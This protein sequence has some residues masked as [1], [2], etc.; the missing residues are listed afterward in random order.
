MTKSSVLRTACIILLLCATTAIA[1]HAQ[2]FTLLAPFDGTNGTS[3]GGVIQGP[4]G[5]FYGITGE[6]GLFNAGTVFRAT[7][8]GAITSLYS[9][10]SQNCTTGYS[11]DY[12]YSPFANLVLGPD[13]D[14]YGTTAWGGTGSNAA[15]SGSGAVGCGTVFKITAS[16]TLTTLHSFSG[17]EGAVPSGMVLGTDGNLYGAATQG[18]ANSNN[19]TIFKIT[20]PSG[21]LT[22]LY[23]FCSQ[24]N[25]TDGGTPDANGPLIQGTDGN[26]YG[27][28]WYSGNP[29]NCDGCS[30]VFKITPGG[31]FTTLGVPGGYSSGGVVQATDGNF[32]G[33]GALAG[34]LFEVTRSGVA[35]TLASVC[36][37]PY[38]PLIQ[39][40][41]GNLYG[42]TFT[43]GN[44]QECNGYGCGTIFEATLPPPPTLLTLYPFCSQTDCT[45]GGGPMS[46]LLQATNGNFYGTTNA[47]YG[48][49][50]AGT[51]FELSTGLG[52]F[53]KTIPTS[54]KVGAK[55]LILGNK[56]K[57]ASSVSFNGTDATFK[58][59]ESA[60]TTTVPAGATTGSIIVTA[61]PERALQSNL[62][63]RVMPQLTSFTPSSG[64]VGT[65]VQ[66]TGV[67][68][69]QTTRVAFDGV[70]ASFTVDSDT[71]VTVTVPTGATTGKIGVTTKG[72]TATSTTSFTVTIPP[73]PQLAVSV[74]SA[75]PTF[76]PGGT[77]SYTITVSNTGNEAT[78]GTITMV[79]TLASAE[80]PGSIGGGSEWVCDLSTVTCTTTI[81]L[82]PGQTFNN[83]TLDVVI[84]SD[85]SGSITAAFTA[86]GDGSIATTIVTNPT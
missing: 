82:A 29:G 2:T 13:G 67:S 46:A 57:N 28:T 59:S 27:V 45:D 78:S 12:G 14:F 20:L 10:C 43:G 9:F 21:T 11:P 63:F 5:N 50:D 17:T 47:D 40:T 68:L 73:A 58:A 66:I 16:G 1:A 15:C 44:T 79:A 61:S 3:P 70:S 86:S 76:A 33:T 60:I 52:P 72:G 62:T 37:Y 25:C 85:A 51:I 35:T 34:T 69:T 4:D 24:A 42:T 36:C 23:D 83:I 8:E 55:V 39:A 81:S 64:P 31:T 18:G 49:Y 32:Y 19:G 22:K 38:G 53:V 26:F 56:L 75:P 48:Q 6:G 74:T 80:T 77:G 65:Q 84:S 7:P 71:Q 41:D 30:T 54:A